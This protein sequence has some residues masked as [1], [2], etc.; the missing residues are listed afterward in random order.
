MKPT[1][2]DKKNI[3]SEHFGEALFERS[4]SKS[5]ESKSLNSKPTPV[6]QL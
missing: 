6:E 1:L 4:R 5:E 3:K 2:N